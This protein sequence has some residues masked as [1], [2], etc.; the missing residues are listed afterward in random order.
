[1]ATRV[2]A[3]GGGNW[4]SGATWVGGVAPTAADDAQL[5]VTSGNVTIDSGAVCRSLDC[6]GYIGTLT[7]PA[8]GFLSVGDATAGA[9]NIA[10]RLAAGMTLTAGNAAAGFNFV[11][12]S[13]TQQ[14][15]ITAGKAVG[16]VTFSSLG[17]GSSYILGDALTMVSASSTLT[18][19]AGTFNTGNFACQFGTVSIAGAAA[20]TLTLG[21]SAIAITGSTGGYGITTLGATNLTITANTAVLT[22]SASS[23]GING[24]NWNGA[25]VVF[26]SAV[27]V[28]TFGGGLTVK[29][30]TW[31][32]PA[33]KTSF[34]QFSSL[35]TTTITGTF[36]ITGNSPVNRPLVRTPTIGSVATVS[37]GTAFSFTNV[38]FMDITATGAAGTW[39]GTS[40]GN[41][42]GNTNITFDAPTTQ[43]R[44]G[45][46]GNWSDIARWTSRVPLPQDNVVV[47]AGASGTITVDM[48]RI[49][50]DIDFTGFAGTATATVG[51]ILYGSLTYSAG[52]TL[53]GTTTQVFGARS[54][55]TITSAGKTH[56]QG[57][58]FCAP[59]GTYTL[60]DNLTAN[61]AM[62]I[63]VDPNNVA[64]PAGT[65]NTNNFN[66]TVGGIIDIRGGAGTTINLGTSTV[67]LNQ[68]VTGTVWSIAPLS[69]LSAASAT[70]VIGNVS[71]NARTFFAGN[72]YSYGTLTYTIAGSTGSLTIIGSS[73][74]G[75]INFSDANNARSLLFTAG[76]TTTITNPNIN[77]TA[78]K[79]MTIDSPTAAQHTL[80]KASGVVEL[81]YVNINHSTAQGGAQWYAGLQSVDGGS[82]T[83]WIFDYPARTASSD[84]FV[85][86][87][88]FSASVV[89][90]AQANSTLVLPNPEFLGYG[91]SLAEGTANTFVAIPTLDSQAATLSSATGELSVPTL[92]VFSYAVSIAEGGSA[93]IL[94]LPEIEFDIDSQIFTLA[95]LIVPIPLIS[96]TA[97]GVIGLPHSWLS[98]IAGPVQTFWSAGPVLMRE[99][100]L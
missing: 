41:A 47:D 43:T 11:S 49:G 9:G 10:L 25:S 68:T 37:V 76:S 97:E 13:A 29:D 31:N 87:L 66:L 86:A 40:L 51:T 61:L 74:F 32:G 90:E 7:I 85:P 57:L 77:G 83:G 15:I 36:S 30:A 72:G 18:L 42:L 5:T 78:G 23:T 55:K 20:K 39:T 46:G 22:F 94:P 50:A 3:P 84:L 27:S 69:I 52:M 79:L 64:V 6:T 89:S 60:L 67:T 16:S 56:T 21:S 17:V 2:A 58:R 73:T 62:G 33:N 63:G 14:T 65:F 92:E 19:A 81:N 24:G 71:A 12:T 8:S 75:T 1:M 70:F 95:N 34:F 48:P 100:S 93:L 26:T 53:G 38:D 80:S 98:A 44:N 96:T 45:A 35:I 28:P 59:G 54:A 99:G 82:N 91:V 88:P 4:T